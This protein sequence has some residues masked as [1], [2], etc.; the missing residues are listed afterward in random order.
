MQHAQSRRRP[1]RFLGHKNIATTV[2]FY[3]EIEMRDAAKILDEAIGRRRA[4]LANPARAPSR[5]GIVNIAHVM[6]GNS[7]ATTERF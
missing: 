6:L 2:K 1:R 3:A 7:L 4:A 5:V